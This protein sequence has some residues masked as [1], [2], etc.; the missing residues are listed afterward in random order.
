MGY[1][2]TT[3]AK[4]Q[5]AK[6]E[7]LSFMAEHFRPA[8][9]VFGD[10]DP[11]YDRTASGVLSED[12]LDYDRG[13]SK[14]GFNYPSWGEIPRYYAFSVCRWMALKA[15]R[16]RRFKKF[17]LPKTSVPYIVY[18]G[19]EAIPVVPE[20]KWTDNEEPE[21][22]SLCDDFGVKAT[23]QYRSYQRMSKEGYFGDQES[24]DQALAAEVE[25]ENTVRQELQ[26]LDSLWEN[27]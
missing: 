19:H 14:M 5:K 4:S 21:R 15:G 12:G 9:E 25:I 8:H 11:D 26:R 3:P 16:I 7:M 23:F 13:T 18:D 6:K 20:S 10:L 24:L 22:F 1:T 27:R 17:D 2:V